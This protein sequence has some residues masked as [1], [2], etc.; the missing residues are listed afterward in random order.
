[1]YCIVIILDNTIP[2]EIGFAICMLQALVFILFINR[3]TKKCSLSMIFFFFITSYWSSAVSRLSCLQTRNRVFFRPLW[4]VLEVRKWV[5]HRWK[6]YCYYHRVSQW[7]SESSQV[8]EDWLLQLKLWQGFWWADLAAIVCP[9]F[10]AQAQLLEVLHCD[11]HCE[12]AIR[13]WSSMQG[14]CGALHGRFLIH[15]HWQL[16]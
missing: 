4:Q 1:M 11:S 2:N 16:L 10:L 5:R 14:F 13:E 15:T 6:Q 9:R 3:H 8:D 12:V 7:K